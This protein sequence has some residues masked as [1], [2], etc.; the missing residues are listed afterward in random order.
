[1][2]T[3]QPQNVQQS[4]GKIYSTVV[5]PAKVRRILEL[6]SSKKGDEISPKISQIFDS[7][8]NLQSI[9]KSSQNE[10]FQL[11]QYIR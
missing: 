6:S 10:V 8:R 5:S 9:K 2:T 4:G 11:Q 3:N 7:A 1:M